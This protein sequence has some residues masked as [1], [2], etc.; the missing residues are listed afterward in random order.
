LVDKFQKGD[1]VLKY[2]LHDFPMSSA[3]A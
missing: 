3:L 2:D 1:L